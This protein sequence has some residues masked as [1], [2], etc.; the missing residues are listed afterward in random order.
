MV[1]NQ[2]H[3]LESGQVSPEKFDFKILRTQGLRFGFTQLQDL[4]YNWQGAQKEYVQKKVDEVLHFKL[5]SSYPMKPATS[6]YEDKKKSLKVPTGE[7]LPD[8][9][10][11]QEWQPMEGDIFIPACLYT[12]NHSCHAWVRQDMHNKTLILLLGSN[13]IIGFQ[14][15]GDGKWVIT[16]TWSIPSACRGQVINAA[17]QGKFKL[18]SPRPSQYDIEIMGMR[19]HFDQNYDGKMCK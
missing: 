8:S 15:N 12:Q 1:M 10:L 7:S 5:D 18:T 6:T 9:F 19:M 16:G 17:E 14:Q 4:K 3:R 2:I 11:K 13:S